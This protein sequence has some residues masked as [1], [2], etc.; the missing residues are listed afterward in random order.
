MELKVC[1][2]CK[3]M[4]QYIT[5]PVLCPKCKQYEEELFQ[6][7]KDYLRENPGDNM[8]EVNKATGVSST[9]IE[10]F[11]RQGRLQVA[12]DSPIALTCE[13]CGKKIATG[14]YCN[15][16]KKEMAEA[17]TDAKKSLTKP[18]AS[19][20]QSGAKMRYLKSKNVHHN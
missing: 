7:V 17:L 16:C 3:K 19:N 8:Y 11:L 10:K 4:F 13:R 9:L 15:E 20:D 5:G 14:K 1:H 18:E 2:G 12:A 6:K